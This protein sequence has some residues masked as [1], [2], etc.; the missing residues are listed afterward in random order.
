[1]N[2]YKTRDAA[3]AGGSRRYNFAM[4]RS[5]RR[6][7][8]FTLLGNVVSIGMVGI[9]THGGIRS[10]W[11]WL[12][13]WA[14]RALRINLDIV[15]GGLIRLPNWIVM[16]IILGL[17]ATVASRLLL[18]CVPEEARP[19]ARLITVMALAWAVV[20]AG[21]W[22]IY[23]PWC[24]DFYMRPVRLNVWTLSDSIL[25][26]LKIASFLCW[27]FGWALYLED[28]RRLGIA[29]DF[30]RFLLFSSMLIGFLRRRLA[31]FVTGL[32]LLCVGV[33]FGQVWWA[34]HLAKEVASRPWIV[35]GF[36]KHV[37]GEIWRWRETPWYGELNLSPGMLLALHKRR[38]SLWTLWYPRR[39]Q[40][41][42]F[43]LMTGQDLP[44]DPDAW[45]AWFK[46]HPNLVWDPKQERMVEPGPTGP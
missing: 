9:M 40:G 33:Y 31:V 37:S 23:P 42:F 46:A 22:L 19:R 11:N 45:E 13:S 10:L 4:L 41:E 39:C 16:A 26:S 21:L 38:T 7:F 18:C 36:S 34:R 3:A 35:R 43:A 14:S 30:S 20:T 29:V 25:P 12:Y 15:V 17:A 32:L 8:L 44:C 2:F 24:A 1:M 6:L 28:Q 27:P 5:W